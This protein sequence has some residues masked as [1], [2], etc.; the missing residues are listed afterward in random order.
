M[1][2]LNGT[3]QYW[4]SEASGRRIS[5]QF[6]SIS[7]S[8]VPKVGGVFIN[9]L[10]FP[11][12]RRQPRAIAMGSFALESLGATPLANSSKGEFPGLALGFWV[13]LVFDS[14]GTH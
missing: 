2:R 1:V 9:R 14:L 3:C 6:Q 5:G 4:A 12:P 13:L 7:P 10:L 11:G 8:L